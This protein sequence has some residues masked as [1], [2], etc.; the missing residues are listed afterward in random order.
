MKLLD[1]LITQTLYER[2]LVLDSIV[3][4]VPTEHI[5]SCACCRHEKT[6]ETAA[7]SEY[8]DASKS[9]IYRVRSSCSVAGSVG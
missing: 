3:T 7:D 6:L 2:D 1:P 5:V 4:H 8:T 9:F